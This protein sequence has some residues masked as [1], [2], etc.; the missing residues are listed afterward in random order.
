MQSQSYRS[1]A[2][3]APIAEAGRISRDI[4]PLCGS[5]DRA[6]V[7][8][9]TR[10]GSDHELVK[11]SSCG[12]V[13]ATTA[14][15][16][17]ADHGE[18]STLYWRFRSRHHQI[19]RLIHLHLKP[20]SGVVEIGCGRGEL[21]YIMKDDPYTYVG[22][23]PASGL[24]RFGQQHGV[25]IVHDFFKRETAPAADAVVIDNVLEHVLD[26]QQLLMDAVMTLSTGGL[27]IVI[28]PN[29]NDLRQIV[30]SWRDARHWIP[31]DHINYFSMTDV[32]RMFANCRLDARSFGFHALTMRDY[33][34]FP[35]AVL[36]T[37][38]IFLLGHNVYALKRQEFQTEGKPAQ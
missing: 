19:R 8:I 26:P 22:Y 25:N 9:I 23:E 3:D 29:R 2:I 38:K 12:F 7:R 27:A 10:L 33:R 5:S 35:R 18:I 11:C 15:F 24:S 1:P 37:M 21:G 36:E 13:Y 31:P 34:Y 6:R 4:C 16:D 14:R 20:G 17:T 28:V 30:P 32:K